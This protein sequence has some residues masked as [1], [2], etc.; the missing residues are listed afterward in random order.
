MAKILLVEDDLDLAR[1]ITRWLTAE[2]HNVELISNGA[3]ALELLDACKFDVVIL[4]WGLPQMSGIE[5]CKEYRARRGCSPIIMLTGKSAT[6]EK[7]TGLDSGA[8]DYL[9]KPFSLRELSARLRALLRRQTSVMP[10]VLAAGDL[11]LDP[12]KFTVT[13]KGVAVALLPKEFAL[14]EFLMRHLDQ[15]F[16]PEALLDRVWESDTEASEGAVRTCIRRLR[17]K[18]DDG[19]D[20]EDCLIQTIPRVG[21]RIRSGNAVHHFSSKEDQR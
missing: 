4:D 5:I 3:E 21:Y 15:T 9:T 10:T 13:R 7:E 16:S 19:D 18:L 8:D 6:V 1:T 11:E 20:D 17:M 14:L 2:N 12:A